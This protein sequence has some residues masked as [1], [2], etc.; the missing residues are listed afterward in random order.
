MDSKKQ[1]GNERPSFL[2]K[3][4]LK[5]VFHKGLTNNPFSVTMGT[6]KESEEQKVKVAK[7]FYIRYEDDRMICGSNEHNYCAA[8][9]LKTAKQ[10][11]HRVKYEVPNSR[12]IRV[13]DIM[14][15][16]DKGHAL[17]VFSIN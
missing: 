6:V 10:I 16:D 1:A 2:R 12:N 4:K 15:D 17:V 8:S 5:K 3:R 13:Y 14:Q 7:R 11:A 9:T